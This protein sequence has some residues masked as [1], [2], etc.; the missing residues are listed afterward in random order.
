MTSLLSG[1]DASGSIG[2]V[3][4]ISVSEASVGLACAAAAAVLAFE[5]ARSSRRRETYPRPIVGALAVLLALVAASCFATGAGLA[6]EHP[7]RV[8][9]GLA[10]A[11][12]SCAVVVGLVL[13]AL[14]PKSICAGGDQPAGVRELEEA[15]RR[16]ER[17]ARR[18]KL[19]ASRTDNA[20]I[21]T[22][23]RW[24]I[25]WVNEGFTRITGYQPDEVHRRVAGSFLQGPETNPSTLAFI[26]QRLRAGEGVQTEILN[27]AKSGRKYWVA[28]EIQPIFGE[29][30]EI[31][32]FLSVQSDVTERKRAERRMEVQHAAMQILAGCSRLEEAIPHLLAT[33]GLTLDF[34]VAE[35][36]LWDH[37]EGALWLAGK[38]WTSSRVGSIWTDETERGR[39]N[40]RS[41]R[42]LK[43]VW[44]TGKPAWEPDLAL[45]EFGTIGRVGLAA[46]CGLRSAV[47]IP[48]AVGE[49]CPAVGVMMFLSRET[50]P[51]DEPLLQA[52]TTL[53]RQIGLFAERKKAV[54]E[55][56]DVNAQLNAVL[57][58]STQSSIIATDPRGVITVFNTGAQRMLGYSAD[59]VIGKTT[60]EVWHDPAEVADYAAKLSAELGTSIQGFE[61]VVARARRD[62]YDS[63]EWTYV[64]K[65]G[66][67]LSVL[68]AVTAVRDPEGRIN[69]F[70]GIAADVSALQRAERQVRESEARLRRLVEANIFGV[71][72]GDLSGKLHDANDAFL[73]MAGYT[74]AELARGVLLWEHVISPSSIRQIHRCRVQLGK[75]GICAPFELEIRRKDG[76][77]LPIL[78]GLALLEEGRLDAGAP[79]VAF[80]LDLT[81]RKR[82]DDELRQHASDLAEA[83]HRKN[84]FLAMLGHELR[85]PLAPIRNAV[86]I[87]KQR[88][89]DDPALTW[90]RDVIDHQVNQLAHL[91][92]DLLEIARVKRGKIRLQLEAV[93]AGVIIDH[94]VET[95]RPIIEA[96]HHRL[97]IAVADEPAFVMA[98]PMRMAQVLSNLLHNA[99]KYTE[100][101]GRIEIS[102]AVEGDQV[103]FRVR[104]DGIGI[105]PSMLSSVFELFTQAD[106]TLDRSQGG[107]GLGLT[108][109]RTLVEMHGGTVDAQSEGL[110]FGSEFTVRLACCAPALAEPEPAVAPPSA[111]LASPA[112]G[113]RILVV[114]DNVTSAESL[115]MILTFEGHDVQVVHDGPSALRTICADCFDVVFMDIGLPDMDGYQVAQKLRARPE[116]ADLPLVAVTGYAEDEARR[117][118]R[119]AGFDEHFVKPVDPDAIH[120]FIASLEWSEK[121]AEAV[122]A[123][124]D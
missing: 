77:I 16:S 15:L 30:G 61:A 78:L 69:G 5:A 67:R 111:D 7:V 93:D 112:R 92:D 4:V 82:L 116:L 75:R 106:R 79:V 20:M 33:V 19:F 117:C 3:A 97:S 55:L 26:R 121:V 86:K 12:D 65:D 43:R 105:Q 83:D 90:S 25:E 31:V 6:A 74:R 100:E 56:I 29:D 10:L 2:L 66:T 115:A 88:G 23:A 8:A 87:M 107:L 110:G 35:F 89:S 37:A 119:E 41:G 101:G 104:D 50:L 47:C 71:I 122:A 17:D 124:L 114:D 68:L 9:L 14:R 62:S 72:F 123:P 45:A 22:D 54:R 60:P 40:L 18:L 28:I 51:R 109:V 94:A 84:Q 21:V 48:V 32:N 46:R 76:R 85:N 42:A 98:D 96:H 59:E 73:E 24:R 63:R 81:E 103:V 102:A 49:E 34:D 99:A 95:S 80:C 108:L 57:D 52:M 53:G 70:L 58:A 13:L 39:A 91:V 1:H 64:R 11:A 27:Y 38:P 120:A 113:R 44:A 36:W 118:S